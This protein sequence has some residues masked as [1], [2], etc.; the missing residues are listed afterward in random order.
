MKSLV[1]RKSLLAI[2]ST[3]CASCMLFAGLSV[4]KASADATPATLESVT[5]TTTMENTASMRLTDP[6]GMRFTANVQ[7]SDIQQFNADTVKVVIMITQKNRLDEA[8][9]TVATF[10]KDS[11]VTKAEVSFTK[12]EFPAADNGTV[13]LI[14]TILRVKDEN[15]AKTYVAKTYITDG[16]KIGYVANATEAS[17]YEVASYWANQDKYKD[18]ATAMAILQGY[19]KS[20]SVTINGN[21]AVKVAYYS[22]VSELFA[23]LPA[24]TTVSSIVDGNSQTVALNAPVTADLALTVEYTV[25]HD[26]ENGECKYCDEV[27]EHSWTDGVCTVCTMACEHTSY[28]DLLCETCGQTAP[29][30]YNAGNTATSAKAY[31]EF[32]LNA[33]QTQTD[34]FEYDV[35]TSAGGKTGNFLKLFV[36]V[37]SGSST[38]PSWMGIT[39]APDITLAQLNALQ[40]AG[41]KNLSVD[42]YFEHYDGPEVTKKCVLTGIFEYGKWDSSYYN[43][44]DKALGQW[45]NFTI[46]I[47]D[48]IANY[49]G[50]ANGTKFFMIIKNS[51]DYGDNAYDGTA[52]ER[53]NA[54]FGNMKFVK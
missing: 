20:C 31:Y 28:K 54:Y 48:I 26:Y 3:L 1:K 22:E 46:D 9:L 10:D 51:K 30:T 14:A 2:L 43:T 49:E 23:T 29:T 32:D 37:K 5:L 18:D 21:E 13:K 36:G 17:I 42:Y 19:S 47:N 33:W 50:L 38:P 4:K 35:A 6:T 39:I 12:D 45:H 27:C 44:A 11:A 40:S 8:G 52:Y 41:Y 7:E 53:F 16:E 34:G 24:C 15:I 25:N